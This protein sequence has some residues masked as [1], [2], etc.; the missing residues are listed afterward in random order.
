M[1]ASSYGTITGPPRYTTMR[2]STGRVLRARSPSG[3]EQEIYAL[4]TTYQAL[5][6]AIADATLTQDD[7]DPDRC[8]F[9]LALAAAREQLIKAEGVIAD[10]VID[11]LGVI[12]D[13]VLQDLMPARRFRISPRVVK[14]AISNYAPNTGKGRL[15]R[16]HLPGHNQYRHPRRPRPLTPSRHG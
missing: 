10:T 12:G 16:P 11:L 4:L 3:I 15:P 1:T 8:S 7:I 13:R 5:R 9:T 2:D 14:R 6:I